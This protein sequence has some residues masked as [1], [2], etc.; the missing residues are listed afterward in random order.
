MM[1]ETTNESRLMYTPISHD[2]LPLPQIQKYLDAMTVYPRVFLNTTILY[3]TTTF[4]LL[5]ITKK[6]E[7]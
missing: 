1:L 3:K 6:G 5:N 7:N 4:E 2:I